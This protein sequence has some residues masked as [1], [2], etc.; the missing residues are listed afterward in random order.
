[1]Y[2]SIIKIKPHFSLLSKHRY[3]SHSSAVKIIQDDT[4]SD[5]GIFKK[6]ENHHGFEVQNIQKIEDFN[7]TAIMLRHT[8]TK[9]EYLHLYRNDGNNVFS[10]NFRTTPKAST[11]LPH[12]L[13]HTVLCG[14]ELFPVR[15][16]FFKMLNRSLSTFMNAMTGSDYTMYPFSTQNLS[17]FRNL[18]RI[19]LDA[20]FR[21]NLKLLD[22]MQEGWRL[23]HVDPSDPKTDIVIKGIVYNE[24]KGAFSDND[25]I[26]AQKLQNFILPDNTYGVI[27]G[28][29]PLKI[30]NLTWED[31]KAFHRNHYHPSNA[32]FYSYGNF[33]LLPTLEYLNDEYLSRFDYKDS[34][35]T[36]VP[37]QQRWSN[38][39]EEHIVCRFENMK[40]AFEKQNVIS[41]SLLMTDITNVHET[42]LIQFVTELLL[43][44][45]NS[46]FYKSLIEENFS[47]GYVSSTG[48]DTQ[49]RDAIFSVGLQG[50]DRKHFS[51]VVA[52]FE[53]TLDSII[54]GGFEQ[55][56]IESVLHRYELG[57]KHESSNFGLNLLFGLTPLWNH[58]GDLIKAL[59]MTKT[60]EQLK[61]EIKVNPKYLQ[62][63]VKKYFKD[64]KHRLILSMSPD[65]DYEK[66]QLELEKDLI[67][68]KVK[69]LS[70]GDREN[71]FTQCL[72]LLKEQSKEQPSD[73]LPT[74]QM[75]DITTEVERVNQE[76]IV[77]IVPTQINKVNSNGVTY[78]RGILNTSQLTP[79]QHMLLPL[80][81]NIITKLGTET[82]NFRDFDSLVNLKTAGLN[83]SIHVGESLY[84]LH[85][86][87]PGILLS[88]Y[89]LNKNV[90]SMFELW[91]QLFN[92][93][94]LKDVD[95]LKMLVQLYVTNLTQGVSDSGHLYAMQ[96]AGALISGV[97]YQKE[98]LSGLQHIS[99][100]KRLV[101]TSS[102]PAVLQELTNI[103]AILFDKNKLR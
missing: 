21:P 19:Y 78:F 63:T 45:P 102:Y 2:R 10:I 32:K 71:V 48:F 67:Q 3:T 66:K 42:F 27:S 23:E 85:T 94:Q 18:Q 52:L 22:F 29:D 30:P 53:K 49:P 84:Q 64:N 12:I 24:M 82:M 56:H 16:P 9:A 43:K 83:L 37:S 89:S 86:Y 91:S 100:M 6:G 75:S 28:G 14:S 13:E 68:Q 51:K 72:E 79:E 88:S 5:Y 4:A 35:H 58:G 98:L 81:C 34:D 33:P 73:L 31:L 95:R 59:N 99:Y 74:L 39:K 7:L 54:A 38:P 36:V 41:V 103:A 46:P 97:G 101:N 90:E 26:Y 57:I 15:D 92:S 44:G 25:S 60:I 80:F 40:E 8:K 76:K 61:N 70:K 20:V 96:A 93:K 55:K 65:K 87:E 77:S 17:D 11:G 50:L 62:D 1:M 47:G 69:K